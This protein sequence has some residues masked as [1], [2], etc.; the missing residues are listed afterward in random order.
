MSSG[1]LVTDHYTKDKAARS[2]GFGTRDTTM[3][4]WELKSSNKTDI[5]TVQTMGW[6]LICQSA[7]PEVRN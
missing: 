4:G 6:D 5:M 3:C 1:W 7:V 2:N